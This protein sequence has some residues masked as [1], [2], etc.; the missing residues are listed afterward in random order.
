MNRILFEKAEITD[1]IATFGG[2]RAEHV[3][4]VLHGE[5]GQILKTGEVDTDRHQRDPG[6]RRSNQGEGESY[7]EVDRAVD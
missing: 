5:V 7:R 3:M 4:N 2:E 1:G 6:D